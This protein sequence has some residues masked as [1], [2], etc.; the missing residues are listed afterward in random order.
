MVNSVRA[1]ME[2]MIPSERYIYYVEST[3]SGDFPEHDDAILNY[4]DDDERLE[5]EYYVPIIPLL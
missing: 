1:F 3:Q 4:L 5:P 2:V